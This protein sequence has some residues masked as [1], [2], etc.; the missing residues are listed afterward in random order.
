[1]YLQG[2][3]GSGLVSQFTLIKD[4][5]LL[6]IVENKSGYLH[7]SAVGDDCLNKNLMN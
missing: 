2:A 1:M 5:H 4:S 3:C 7:S 6:V